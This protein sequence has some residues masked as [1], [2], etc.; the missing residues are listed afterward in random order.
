[1]NEEPDRPRARNPQLWQLARDVSEAPAQAIPVP[2]RTPDEFT[3]E[4]ER[5]SQFVVTHRLP[6]LDEIAYGKAKNMMA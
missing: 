4:H 1:M 3:E 6:Y 5:F 2:Y